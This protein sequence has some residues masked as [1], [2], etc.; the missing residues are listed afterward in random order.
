MGFGEEV[1]AIRE[2]WRASGF[3]A[4]SKQITDRLLDGLPLVA[5]ESVAEVLEQVKAYGEA[6][7]TRVIMP[8]VPCT[9]DVVAEIREFIQ[10]F[11]RR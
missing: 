5:G 10:A 3:H 4:A 7:A 6:G 8:Y 11:G 2:T 1:A 9:D